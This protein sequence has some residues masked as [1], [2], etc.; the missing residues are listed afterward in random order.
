MRKR[1][2]YTVVA[3]LGLWWIPVLQA[4][5]ELPDSI[6]EVP[7][8]EAIPDSTYSPVTATDQPLYYFNEISDTPEIFER[9]LDTSSV[10]QVR[11]DKAYWYVNTAPK[12]KKAEQAAPSTRVQDRSWFQTI[13]WILLIAGFVGL[14]GWFL[15]ASNIRLFRRAPKSMA[16]E[17]QPPGEPGENIFELDFNREINRA[18]AAENYRL[19][20]RLSYLQILR[21]LSQRELIQYSHE[22]TNS[23][24]LQQLAGTRSYKDF[25]RITRHFEY[26]WYGGFFLNREVYSQMEQDFSN[27]KKQLG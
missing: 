24:Y 21:E 3:C 26:T 25:F 20:I 1:L 18:I 5:E 19:A 17:D 27:F 14:L 13:F 15:A 10:N 8:V 11:S 4:Q 6:V 22:K 2:F 9:I 12:R 16:G 23:D 7:S